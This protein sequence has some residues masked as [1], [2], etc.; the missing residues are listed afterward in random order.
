MDTDGFP[1]T[2]RDR[3]QMTPE[4]RRRLNTIWEQIAALPAFSDFVVSAPPG[5]WDAGPESRH[6]QMLARSLT[7]PAYYYRMP[8]TGR[9]ITRKKFIIRYR[10]AMA[11]RGIWVPHEPFYVPIKRMGAIGA[12]G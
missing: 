2:S 6:Q 3:K 10:R 4:V 12:K 5:S 11:R 8:S 9:R 1:V 7:R